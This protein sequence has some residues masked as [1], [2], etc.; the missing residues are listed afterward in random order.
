MR[1]SFL[2]KLCLRFGL[3]P[4]LPYATHTSVLHPN[5][6]LQIHLMPTQNP[7]TVKTS[8]AAMTTIILP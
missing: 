6:D 4:D 1:A 2:V 3:T 5:M 7:I 8:M